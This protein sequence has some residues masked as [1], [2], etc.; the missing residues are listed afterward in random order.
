MS[1]YWGRADSWLICAARIAAEPGETEEGRGHNRQLSANYY[2]YDRQRK[3]DGFQAGLVLDPFFEDYRRVLMC[4]P[5][6]GQNNKTQV[7]TFD[8]EGTTRTRLSHSYEVAVN[9]AKIYTEFLFRHGVSSH[10]EEEAASGG[11]SASFTESLRYALMAAC[12]LHDVGNPPFGH[13]GEA[14][15]RRWF[16][17]SAA[18]GACED[19]TPCQKKDL[20]TFEG[21]ANSVRIALNSTCMCDGRR[22]NLTATTIVALVKY[23]YKALD[24]NA[25]EEQEGEDCAARSKFNYFSD[26]F[27]KLESYMKDCGD[28]FTKLTEGYRHPLSFFLEASDDVSYVT[29]DFED[30]FRKQKFTVADAV[31]FLLDCLQKKID[32]ATGGE[33]VEIAENFSRAVNCTFTL[34]CLLAA[35]AGDKTDRVLCLEFKKRNNNI[36]LNFLIDPSCTAFFEPVANYCDFLIMER[37]PGNGIAW[38]H[39]FDEATKELFADYEPTSDELHQLR[40]TYVSRWVDVAR[41]WLC[42]SSAA[43]LMGELRELSQKRF[44]GSEDED[45]IDSRLF[46][47]HAITVEALKTT[48]KH[49]VYNSHDNLLKNAHAETVLGGLLNLFVPAA[50]ECA[51][52]RVDPVSLKPDASSERGLEQTSLTILRLI[53]LRY[54]MDCRNRLDGKE[55][56][57]PFLYIMMVLDYIS[58]LSDDGAVHLYQKVLN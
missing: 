57:Q 33:H 40:E 19:L 48:M 45:D 44:S 58:S 41:D 46:G 42:F 36:I 7:F 4:L 24:E 55:G 50:I 29:S 3:S 1:A 13:T 21:N 22:L 25:P 23:P 53:P 30:A 15:I 16:K 28:G 38:Q 49:F 37:I 18:V 47:N 32:R 26:D 11:S 8:K 6:R 12:L 9:A 27:E 39:T 56:H 14:V 10:S 31:A 17:E 35:I 20:A 51:S 5:F 34:I 2:R 52:A 54:R 43:S